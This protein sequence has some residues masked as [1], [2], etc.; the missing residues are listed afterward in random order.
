MGGC[1][2]RDGIGVFVSKSH[3]AHALIQ[4][5][6]DLGAAVRD[7]DDATLK[8]LLDAGAHIDTLDL[9][10]HSLLDI[11]TSENKPRCR[12]LL[13]CS[14]ASLGARGCSFYLF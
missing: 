10:G 2:S 1:C 8:R 14:L 5:A 6:A 12:A 4:Q 13:L 11:A 3:W 7:D 9:D